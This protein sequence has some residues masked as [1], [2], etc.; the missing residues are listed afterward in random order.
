VVAAVRTLAALV[1]LPLL[2][3]LYRHDFLVLVALRPSLGILLLGAILARHGGMSLWAMLL[4]AVPL[5]LLIVW[6]YFL[7]GR[8]WESEI[9]SED[10]LPFLTARLLQRNQVR[11]IREVLKTHGT[12]LVV[13]ARFAIF[14]TGLLA[15]TAGASNMK[16]ARYFPA[17]G[18][19]FAVAAGLVV[20]AG[21]GLGLAQRQSDLWLTVIGAIG[22][23]T[24]SG[25]LT[26]Y[27]RRAPK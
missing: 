21:Y 15:A 25:L 13:L 6:L 20:G 24:L 5:Q 22:L 23:I 4:I 12:R 2:P 17:D 9:H 16:P 1:A 8:A 19:A 11:R 27:V 18:L 14:P 7:L 3:V 26:W 10:E